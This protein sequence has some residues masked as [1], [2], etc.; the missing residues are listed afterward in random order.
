MLQ[1]TVCKQPALGV[2]DK[3]RYGVLAVAGGVPASFLAAINIVS[4]I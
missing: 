2:A 1:A 3:A 4:R